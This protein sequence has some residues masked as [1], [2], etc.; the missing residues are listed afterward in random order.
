MSDLE[1]TGAGKFV[2]AHQPARATRPTAPCGRLSAGT[3]ERRRR[4]SKQES[5]LRA[6]LP[7]HLIHLFLPLYDNGREPLPNGL[8]VQVREELLERFG[9]LT[10]HPSPRQG[11]VARRRQSRGARRAADLRDH[12]ERARSCL[13]AGLSSHFGEALSPGAG[14]DPSAAGRSPVTTRIDKKRPMSG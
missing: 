3:A 9:G 7:M 5:Y 11:A 4:R 12:D 1:S 2:P 6:E 14:T 8:F 10:A 13:V